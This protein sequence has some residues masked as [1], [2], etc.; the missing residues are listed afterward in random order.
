MTSDPSFH[1]FGSPHQE[2]VDTSSTATRSSTGMKSIYSRPI[3]AAH[4]LA[5][6]SGSSGGGI[7]Y[8]QVP[9]KDHLNPNAY[10]DII[11]RALSAV[12][13]STPVS[14][15]RARAEIFDGNTHTPSNVDF[16]QS[17]LIK[18]ERT[19][20]A[21]IR[22]AAEA[23]PKV[24]STMSTPSFT[25]S[26]GD[27]DEEHDDMV[28]T[29]SRPRNSN[30]PSEFHL[31]DSVEQSDVEK[32]FS[33]YNHS[34]SRLESLQSTRI[35]SQD[36]LKD[37]R[38]QSLS[39]HRR[40]IIEAAAAAPHG[41]SQFSLGDKLGKL[42]E[43]FSVVTEAKACIKLPHDEQYVFGARHLTSN[44]LQ[45]GKAQFKTELQETVVVTEDA[46]LLST[47]EELKNDILNTRL[48]N[49]GGHSSKERKFQ[50][51]KAKLHAKGLLNDNAMDDRE[52][53]IF[54]DMSNVYLGF[55]H[56][57]RYLRGRSSEYF[58][59]YVPFSFD[60]FAHILERGRYIVK[61]HLAGS[62]R[63]AYQKDNWPT[64]II[65]AQTAH[66][67][68]NIFTQVEKVDK[69]PL[70]KRWLRK[71]G[72]VTI[73]PS[74]ITTSGDE[75]SD[76]NTRTKLGE[77]GV[78]E[79]IHLAM[80]TSLVDSEEPQTMVLATGD[81]QQAE[82]SEGFARYATKALDHGWNIEIVSW[83]RSLS[84]EW[85]RLKKEYPSQLRIIELDPFFDEI[86]AT[87]EHLRNR[88]RL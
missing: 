66:Y 74:W 22:A 78:D 85:P 26:Y 18:K 32:G 87:W 40:V 20:F 38:L 8:T 70:S 33:E 45:D 29:P 86:H 10:E 58:V 76:G 54:I 56:E 25:S 47:G 2:W 60:H 43:E 31:L 21:I 1:G 37:L 44:N 88:R 72:G 5:E 82:F 81:A 55:Q 14:N 75:S 69:S 11:S 49:L 46:A 30:R 79:N 9:A 27:E 71:P 63:Y 36:P 34:I 12:A 61:R 68:C 84:S 48:N 65:E 15:S 28:F 4:G 13:P 80:M 50:R 19:Y 62:I 7:R 67:D 59:P 41:S 3:T 16:Q 23:S 57:S 42:Q 35:S 83:K 39:I 24:T 6:G 77:Q 53:H 73:E 64:H 51:L 17:E 52:V